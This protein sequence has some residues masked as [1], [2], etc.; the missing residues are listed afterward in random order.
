MHHGN[1][2]N[3]WPFLT[4]CMC[5]IGFLT[6]V[7]LTEEYNLQIRS[8]DGKG[9]IGTPFHFRCGSEF[10]EDMRLFINKFVEQK[11]AKKRG[12]KW[13]VFLF[14]MRDRI[15]KYKLEQWVAP[16]IDFCPIPWSQQHKNTP[17]SRWFDSDSQRRL[18]YGIQFPSMEQIFIDSYCCPLFISST[19]TKY[20]YRFNGCVFSHAKQNPS[21]LLARLVEF[22]KST[23]R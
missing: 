18:L 12:Y 5:E 23:H 21:T 8:W 16:P 13:G 10:A 1:V 3:P 20:E 15:H 11:T 22:V 17:L 6:C 2:H 14:A 7:W 4:I 9:I 19:A